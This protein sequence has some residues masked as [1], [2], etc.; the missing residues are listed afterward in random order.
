M[1]KST[2]NMRDA[3]SF[4]FFWMGIF[5][6]PIPLMFLLHT[7]LDIR[8]FNYF[9]ALVSVI[10]LWFNRKLIIQNK[11]SV[12]QQIIILFLLVTLFSFWF[13][14]S[15]KF[16]GYNLHAYDFG[17]FQS[18]IDNII[19]KNIGYSSVVGFYHFGTHQ[20]YILF[21]I[22][23]FYYIFH[24][25]LTLQI[26]AGS[27]IWLTMIVIYFIAKEYKLN[28]FMIF[29]VILSFSL[30][31]LNG[32]DNGFMPET[33]MPL[34]Y[35]AMFLFY[36]RKKYLLA[37]IFFLLSL[38]TKED[39]I[40][41]TL[42]FGVLALY[43]KKYSFA[44]FVIVCSLI[45]GYI[46]LGVIQ[47]YFVA[48]SGMIN[49]TTLGQWS[50]WGQSKHEIVMNMLLGLDK[51][52]YSIFNSTS[53]IYRLYLPFLFLTTIIPEVILP[54]AL[55]ILM[56]ATS[57]NLIMHSY[58]DYYGMTLNLINYI[59]IIILLSQLNTNLNKLKKLLFYF[60]TLMLFIF[61]L[62]GGGYQTFFYFNLNYIKSMHRLVN[63]V[64]NNYKNNSLCLQDSLSPILR[65]YD[66]IIPPDKCCNNE[67]L[68]SSK[69]CTIVL[70]TYGKPAPAWSKPNAPELK[71]LKCKDYD[72]FLFCDRDK[73]TTK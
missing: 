46:N 6:L 32:L 48:K 53:G 18:L 9:W 15:S 24:S 57:N 65:P 19:N 7:N 72:G 67:F 61:P 69:S 33:F 51:V 21:L 70:T 36:K 50:Q 43:D 42:G 28:T 62:L 8:S 66:F 3:T 40:L 56:A 38:L 30:S 55:F 39:A 2:D 71:D 63:I 17:I 34:F 73:A 4:V 60:M 16:L 29:I 26:I 49:P 52:F 10:W 22:V 68:F 13:S 64:E 37:G 14:L 54:S 59:G 12:N 5:I 41:Y 44:I 23:P 27:V 31:P 45:V 20:N 1:V 35:S 47:P 25:A 58:N 11:I